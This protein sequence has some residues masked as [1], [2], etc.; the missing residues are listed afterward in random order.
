MNDWT[1][2][3][4][5]AVVWVMY[6]LIVAGVM[7]MA[8]SPSFDEEW[9]IA[10]VAL[11]VTVVAGYATRMIWRFSP[12]VD[13][14]PVRTTQGRAVSK[15]KRGNRLARLVDDLS[16]DEIVELETLLLSREDE[17]YQ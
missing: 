7:A 15:G 8:M 11:M 3:L 14:A 13:E 2:F 1:R 5:T 9:I 4:S 17:D 10:V 6:G 12:A 16:E